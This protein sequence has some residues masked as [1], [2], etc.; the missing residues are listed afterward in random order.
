M[1]PVLA[2]AYSPED[3]TA[4][5]QQP[6]LHLHPALQG[7]MG[8]FF[9]SALGISPKQLIIETHSE[10]ML[11]R[12]LKRIRQTNGDTLSDDRLKISRDD[13]SVLYFDPQPNGS[14][15]I[16]NLRISLDGEFMDRWPK[17]F[18]EERYED[19]FDE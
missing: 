19:L 12:I 5:I 17:G 10:H 9:I 18:F 16:K 14:T 1:L 8:D 7:R 4:F 13:V 15:K 6:E 11:L 2:V 3:G